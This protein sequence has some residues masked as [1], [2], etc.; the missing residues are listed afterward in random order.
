MSSGKPPVNTRYNR[1]LTLVLGE[2]SKICQDHYASVDVSKMDELYGPSQLPPASLPSIPDTKPEPPRMPE[3]RPRPPTAHTTVSSPPISLAGSTVTQ[4][5]AIHNSPGAAPSSR[6]PAPSLI[7]PHVQPTQSLLPSLP[8]TPHLPLD[9]H[10]A[11]IS[12]FR[13]FHEDPSMWTPNE[14]I[15]G[16]TDLFKEAHI[17][18][19]KD[20]AFSRSQESRYV[21][22]SL[23]P[24]PVKKRKGS[25][26]Q[27]IGEVFH[28]EADC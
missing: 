4:T 18:K 3:R 13:K 26:M 2:V 23:P 1:P 16:S 5:T 27:I 9:T 6:T 15:K 14:R 25:D 17:A 8:S 24:R 7:D 19:S 21:N 28:E 12:L 20:N 22:T 11:L 10:D